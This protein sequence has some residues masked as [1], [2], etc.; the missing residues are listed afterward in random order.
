MWGH[1]AGG[2]L[3]TL[4]ALSGNAEPATDPPPTP[5]ACAVSVS[6]PTDFT[7]TIGSRGGRILEYWFGARLG[8]DR[9]TSIAREA[10]PLTYVDAA[11]PP[12]LLVHGERDQLV[13]VQ[14]SVRLDAALREAGVPSRLIR[15]EGQG[16]TISRLD[17]YVRV[18]RFFDEQLGG[19]A[20]TPMRDSDRLRRLF[21]Y[22]PQP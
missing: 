9:F 16:H 14:Q 6:G 5:V 13:P 20:A 4:L 22:D 21:S 12:I 1:S 8:T 11:D 2:H 19:E 3:S 7:G 15:L 18:A 10:S 17:A